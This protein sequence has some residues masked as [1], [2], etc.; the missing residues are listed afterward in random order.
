VAGGRRRI[1]GG[2]KM[3][4]LGKWMLQLPDNE[5]PLGI[6]LIGNQWTVAGLPGSEVGQWVAYDRGDGSIALQYLILG[7]SLCNVQVSNGYLTAEL[8]SLDQNPADA[9]PLQAALQNGYLSLQAGDQNVFAGSAVSLQEAGQGYPL[10]VAAGSATTVI[11]C[12]VVAPGIPELQ[13]S[14]NGA[15]SDYSHVDLSGADLSNCDLSNSVFVETNL[16]DVVLEHA[17]LANADLTAAVIGMDA[18]L[19]WDWVNLTNAKLGSQWYVLMGSLRGANLTGANFSGIGGIILDLTAATD[20]TPTNFTGTNFSGI[21]FQF[22]KFDPNPQF[23]QDAHQL[24]DFSGAKL[25]ISQLPTTTASNQQQV[26]NWTNLRLAGTQISGL[27]V[28]ANGILQLAYLVAN[29]VDMSGWQLPGANLQH[30]LLNN[31]VLAGTGLS[32]ANLNF[33]QL[34]SAWLEALGDFEPATLSGASMLDTVLSNAHLSGVVMSGVYLYGQG[35]TLAGATMTLVK[36]SGAYLANLDF[37]SVKDLSGA[38][39]AQACL[40][41]ATF[42][43]VKLI[44]YQGPGVETNPSLYQACLQ[45]TDFSQ[46][47][48]YGADMTAAAIAT[49][50][51]SIP[52][53]ILVNGKPWSQKLTFNQPTQLPPNVTDATTV[54]P[55]GAFGPCGSN[56]LA[57]LNS[58]T[59]WPVTSAS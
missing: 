8:G 15:G 9:T 7:G 49:A 12:T 51:G 4:F 37:S 42:G 24:T 22:A 14:H 53:T 45:G 58:P 39:F 11:I 31:A 34:D 40:V 59:Q 5:G 48:L 18:P 57:N 33:A 27:P 29:A 47:E 20:G 6:A 26:P 23:S 3:T 46:S 13:Q 50:S 17:D 1:A 2:W 35:A 44:P 52:V 41:N 25:S 54:C 36:L 43:Q 10:Q 32:Q 30:A 28:D 55:N 56:T 21:D 19:R 16:T 38:N